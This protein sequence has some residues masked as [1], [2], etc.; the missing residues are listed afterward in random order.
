M[1][2]LAVVGLI[3]GCQSSVPDASSTP[4]GT[5]APTSSPSG[6]APD[7]PMPSPTP[8]P[9]PTVEACA[10]RVAELDREDRI[11]QLLMVAIDSTGL[12][13]STAETLDEVHAGSVLLLGNTD[14]GRRAIKSVTDD[15]REAIETPE[16][17]GVLLAAD[18]E[19][20]Q[21]QRLSGSGFN[22]IPSAE[23]QADLSDGEL[24]RNA[25]EW[26]KELKRAGIDANLAPV[27]DVVP[28]ELAGTNEPIAGLDRGYGSDPEQV[29][30]KVAA[31]T[32]GMAAAEIATSLKH[33]P[34]LGQVRGNTD[35]T[36]KVTDSE[37]GPDDPGFAAFQAGIDAGADMI[38]ASNAYYSKIDPK[39]QAVFSNK[40]ISG[41]VRDKLG[42]D[43]VVISDD[44][45]AEGVADL[46]PTR[47]AT[48]FIAAGGDLMIIGDPS[49]AEDMADALEDKAEDDQDFDRRISESATRVVALKARHG[50]ASC[51]P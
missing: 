45:A 36:A 13:S 12:A 10:A 27:A 42:F 44:L 38:M 30:K 40:I 46:R 4:D 7:S 41:I 11:G 28:K 9:T 25:E 2:T 49:L 50:L 16:E 43:G 20:G 3:A 1:A 15:A 26:G 22:T 8:T 51:S 21:V 23:E 33:F 18:Q 39:R 5:S 19:G 24:R 29:G 17:I 37:T 34:G 6:P 31:F 14:G 47:R 35:F 48:E 32:E